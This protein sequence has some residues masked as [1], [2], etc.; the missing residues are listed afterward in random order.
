[1]QFDGYVVAASLF[2]NFETDEILAESLAS[3]DKFINSIRVTKIN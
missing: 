1:M 3:R 2:V